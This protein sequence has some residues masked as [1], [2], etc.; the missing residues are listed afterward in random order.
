MNIEEKHYASRGVGGT[1]L[2]LS[3]G[4]LG[5]QLLSGGLGNLFGGGARCGDGTSSIATLAA[6]SLGSHASGNGENTPVN[7]YELGLQ[8]EITNK[9]MEIAY[10]KGRD[11][12]K[13]DSI[14]LYRYVDGRFNAIEG[15]IAAQAVVNAQI[16]ANISCMQNSI[17]ALNGLT[18]TVIPIGNVC[19]EPM[20]RY[21]SWTAPTTTDTAAG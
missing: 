4:S 19:P 9:D 1:A 7:R 17:A 20:Q 13:T 18:K 21:N 11:A 10:L 3:I 2:G 14:E 12:A 6:L 5:A 15:Q 16:T 8:K